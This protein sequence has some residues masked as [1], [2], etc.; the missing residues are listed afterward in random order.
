VSGPPLLAIHDLAVDFATAR[1]PVRAVRDVSLE[2]TA[3]ECLAV[4]GESGSGKSQL[5]LAC[6]G[7]LAAR[8]ACRGSARWRGEELIGAPART[9]QSV[10]GTQV[11]MVFQ[12]PM[13][14]LTPHMT[15]GRQLGEGLLDRGQ[16]G[17]V[18]VRE[19]ALASL[20]AVGMA[21]AATRL[22]QYPHELSGGQRQRV[23][24][25]MALMARPQLLVADEPTTAL[26]VTVQAQVMQVLR[27][28]R[29][30]GLSLVLITHDLGVVAGIADRV[31]IM[32]AGRIVETAP[33]RAIFATPAHPYT[34][35]LLAAVP[36]LAQAPRSRLRGIE[37]QPPAPGEVVPGCAFAPRCPRVLERCRRETP[38]LRGG[39]AGAVACHAPLVAQG[40]DP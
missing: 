9:L 31:A 11:G 16:V 7:L 34:A 27:R 39:S 6:L 19:R 20:H 33:V 21:D 29:G 14:A 35:A 38:A 25:A 37:G 30:S 12:D 13:N 32:Y 4:V 24:I 5:F 40:P 22:D 28:A 2:V 36:R 3:G 8:G 18:E 23:A 10:R 17:P 26:D 1:G 15:I